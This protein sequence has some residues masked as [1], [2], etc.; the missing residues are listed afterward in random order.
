VRSMHFPDAAGAAHVLAAS[1]DLE[2]FLRDPA[3]RKARR[4]A[5][6]APPGR[7]IGQ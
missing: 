7:P 1:R 4:V 5:P 3:T 2:E 6:Q